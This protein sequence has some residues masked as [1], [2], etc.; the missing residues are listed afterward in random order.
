MFVAG[1]SGVVG[2]TA[3]PA[4]NLTA[5]PLTGP[6][7]KQVVLDDSALS[8]II[9]PS[10]RIDPRFSPRLGGPQALQDDGSA[11]PVD[12]LGV[13]SMLRRDVYQ[14]GKVTHVAVETWRQ[15]AMSMEGTGVTEG[16]VS[17]PTAADAQALFAEFSRQWRKCDGRTALLP[18]SVF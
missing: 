12:C 3:R 1:C 9:N 11:S 14:S 7:I 2:G 17:L 16:V 15:A 13:A 18:E 10:F 6:T 8:R 4:A 5:R